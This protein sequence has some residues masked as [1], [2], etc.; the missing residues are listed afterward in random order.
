VVCG[1]PAAVL[2][3][4]G[5][6]PVGGLGRHADLRQILRQIGGRTETYDRNI[7]SSRANGSAYRISYTAK[8]PETDC[9]FCALEV[10]RLNAPEPSALVL[11][12]NHHA[13]GA[14]PEVAVAQ[15]TTGVGSA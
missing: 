13:S 2:V 3:K 9:R 15:F 6:K 4:N 12:S 8:P 11:V 7:E 1:W 14:G 5:A 10:R